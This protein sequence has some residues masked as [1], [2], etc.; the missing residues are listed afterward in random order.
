MRI[1]S[2]FITEEHQVFH[3]FDHAQ[4]IPL[5]AAQGFER[6]VGRLAAS[7]TVAIERVLKRVF[8]FVP[9]A[10]AQAFA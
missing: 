8:H 5:D 1:V 6:G 7:R 4:P 10:A 9:D 2:A 3:A